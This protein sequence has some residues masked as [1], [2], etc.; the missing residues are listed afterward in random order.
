MEK[1]T[2]AK[3]TKEK[4]RDV[5][6]N[7]FAYRPQVTEAEKE[8]A[9]KESHTKNRRKK[10]R[11]TST[12]NRVRTMASSIPIHQC[13]FSYYRN[14]I[15]FNRWICAFFAVTYTRNR[16]ASRRN[17]IPSLFVVLR[18]FFVLFS[19]RHRSSHLRIG[20]LHMYWICMFSIFI[21]S[22]AL[23]HINVYNN[24]NWN[25][26]HISFS[27]W[28]WNQHPLLAILALFNPCHAL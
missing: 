8:T 13:N 19:S 26:N 25:H 22:C 1:R 21:E 10:K 11:S 3:A 16:I 17:C 24:N 23:S 6:V 7:E 27:C 18:W 28:Y 20:H 2:K 4:C 5:R 12:M 14:F 9:R 15:R